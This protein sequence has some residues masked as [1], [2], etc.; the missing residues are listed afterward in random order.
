MATQLTAKHNCRVILLNGK[1]H[2]NGKI[3]E[4]VLNTNPSGIT[5]F[6]CD[7]L[8]NAEL[9]EF[10][11]TIY[12]RFDGID[13]VIDNGIVERSTCLPKDDVDDDV[14]AFVDTTG[15]RLRKTINVSNAYFEIL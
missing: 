2:K 9:E 1:N 12:D 5:M 6:N 7:I 13:I 14:R 4:N 8:N 10:S 11:Q 3:D 15:D